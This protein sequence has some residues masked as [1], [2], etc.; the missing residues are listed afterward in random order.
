[1]ADRDSFGL[2]SAEEMR[3]FLISKG[4][5]PALAERR[6][7]ESARANRRDAALGTLLGAAGGAGALR[8]G[9]G[10]ARA[11]G[12]SIM[13]AAGAALSRAREA[14]S[15]AR[16]FLTQ[17][18]VPGVGFAR[19]PQTGYALRNVPPAKGAARPR[20]DLPFG[21]NL[22]AGPT[23]STAQQAVRMGLPAAGAVGAARYGADALDR[24]VSVPAPAPDR[25]Y[26]GDSPREQI[27]MREMRQPPMPDEVSFA[28][29]SER[30]VPTPPR[31]P[32][33]VEQ[34]APSDRVRELF[35]RYNATGNPADFILASNAMREAGITGTGEPMR[36][37]AEGG[38]ISGMT[39]MGGSG[40]DK[41]HKDAALHK[42]LEII[43][44]LIS[45][46]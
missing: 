8:S 40:G 15:A 30:R 33:P 16:S 13:D 45:S 46:R 27:A 21:S 26:E 5:D 6:A 19:N 36:T 1:M 42:A 22:P 2:P 7:M 25:G 43:H 41:M 32:A 39:G 24:P 12:P 18:S 38:A 34:A 9:I 10:A 3:D 35:D 37:K 23:F 14:G 4:M 28:A 20:P 44:A 29:R 17:P 11:A 31:R